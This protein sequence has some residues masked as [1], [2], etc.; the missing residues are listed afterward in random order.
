MLLI[1]LLITFI[2]N[3]SSLRVN[4][5]YDPSSRTFKSQLELLPNFIDHELITELIGSKYVK[6]NFN[7]NLNDLHTLIIMKKYKCRDDIECFTRIDTEYYSMK[8]E[9]DMVEFF[10]DYINTEL[11]PKRISENIYND[12][13]QMFKH[14]AISRPPNEFYTNIILHLDSQ[15]RRLDR[16]VDVASV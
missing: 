13:K 15:I 3:I 8:S 1:I 6:Y 2:F 11:V 10:K 14:I 12:L 4:G 16:G 7:A 5:L 9:Y